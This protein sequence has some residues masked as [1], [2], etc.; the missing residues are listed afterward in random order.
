P[1]S[2]TV[3]VACISR[4]FAGGRTSDLPRP[5]GI[6]T[7]SARGGEPLAETRRRNGRAATGPPRAQE[8]HHRMRDENPRYGRMFQCY[9]PSPMQSLAFYDQAAIATLVG[10][11]EL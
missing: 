10:F 4:P 2:T 1:S 5:R 6:V 7:V 3:S 9:A 11:E 8:Q